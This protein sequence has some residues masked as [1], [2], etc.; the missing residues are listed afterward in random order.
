MPYCS[1]RIQLASQ[2]YQTNCRSWRRK[3]GSNLTRRFDSR[4]VAAASVVAGEV[5]VVRLSKLHTPTHAR[6]HIYWLTDCYWLSLFCRRIWLSSLSLTAGK[7]EGRRE[8]KN[9]PEMPK[10]PANYLSFN[11]LPASYQYHLASKAS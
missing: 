8:K 5:E 11:L 1:F 10:E 4:P 7:K 9:T 2:L 3:L 6:T